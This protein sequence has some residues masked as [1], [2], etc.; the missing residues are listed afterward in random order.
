MALCLDIVVMMFG[1]LGVRAASTSKL[2]DLSSCSSPSFSSPTSAPTSV[3][4]CGGDK[5]TEFV[6]LCE[7][8][9]TLMGLEVK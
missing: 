6:Y 7:L 9:F 4:T 8:Q 3:H 1:R 5:K 2:S